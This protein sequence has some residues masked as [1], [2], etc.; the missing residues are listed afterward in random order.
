MVSA[1]V[2]WTAVKV[3][4]ALAALLIGAV[5]VV[6]CCKDERAK[7]RAKD[8]VC[9][10]FDTGD[11]VAVEPRTGMPITCPCSSLCSNYNAATAKARADWLYSTA[12]KMAEIKANGGGR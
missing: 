7:E 1:S 6:A 9:P 2:V 4:A 3:V 12:N 10:H 8:G 11:C 5:C